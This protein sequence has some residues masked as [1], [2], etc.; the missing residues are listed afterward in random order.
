MVVLGL[1]EL[2]MVTSLAEENAVMGELRVF[3]VI[4]KDS[5]G[6]ISEEEGWR[7]VPEDE[8]LLYDD[9]F[10]NQFLVSPDMMD[11]YMSN[12]LAF[13]ESNDMHDTQQL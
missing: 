5:E 6:E 11:Q 4:E 13:I 1:G 9:D 12:E 2:D 3:K 7:I 8:T 10:L